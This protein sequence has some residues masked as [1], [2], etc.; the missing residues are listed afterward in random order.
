[1]VRQTTLQA[2]LKR[3][4]LLRGPHKS[5]RFIND[6]ELLMGWTDPNSDLESRNAVFHDGFIANRRRSENSSRSFMTRGT[7]FCPPSLPR[8]RIQQ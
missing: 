7:L 5:P 1:M 2:W 6:P 4:C 8:W 3:T